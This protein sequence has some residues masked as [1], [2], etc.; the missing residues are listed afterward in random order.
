MSGVTNRKHRNNTPKPQRNPD[1]RAI[2]P[3]ILLIHILLS[4]W[5]LSLTSLIISNPPIRNQGGR[6]DFP[7]NRLGT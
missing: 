3:K 5:F 1:I 4:P 7:I 2:Q 6:E